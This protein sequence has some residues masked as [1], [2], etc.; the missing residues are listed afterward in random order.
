MGKLTGASLFAE[1]EPEVY[2]DDPHNMAFP[3]HPEHA[4]FTEA[5]CPRIDTIKTQLKVTCPECAAT[6]WVRPRTFEHPFM[7]RVVF[8]WAASDPGG[9]RVY[10]VPG[11]LL[12]RCDSP[13][14]SDLMVIETPEDPRPFTAHP[15]IGLFGPATTEGLVGRG[16]AGALSSLKKQ[17]QGWSEWKTPSARIIAMAMPVT[18]NGHVAAGAGE[19]LL[20]RPWWRLPSGLTA[21]NAFCPRFGRG[22]VMHHSFAAVPRPVK[23]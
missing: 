22:V 13:V 1:S 18:V 20:A 2:P 10:P 8:E 7:V 14:W 9:T 11:A 15:N 23:E 6:Y 19:V 4:P 12:L 5:S 3:C 21:V 16:Y 17:A